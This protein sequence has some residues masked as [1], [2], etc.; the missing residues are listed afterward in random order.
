V[1]GARKDAAVVVAS[2]AGQQRRELG[3]RRETACRRS[4]ARFLVD[5]IA[6]KGQRLL[7]HSMIHVL[8]LA[9]LPDLHIP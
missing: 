2:A 4:P 1:F 5:H 9:S 7:P 6:V 8:V 3:A